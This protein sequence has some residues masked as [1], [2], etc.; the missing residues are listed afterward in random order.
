MIGKQ[1]R[2]L[3]K[4]AENATEDLNS[5]ITDCSD[6]S[7][8]VMPDTAALQLEYKVEYMNHLVYDIGDVWPAE[9]DF[10]Q[11]ANNANVVE[12]TQ[13]MDSELGNRSQTVNMDQL[14]RL[15]SSYRSWPEFRNTGTVQDII[16]GFKEDQP[17]KMPIVVEYDGYKQ[18][19]SGNTRLDI[20]FMMKVTPQ[21]LWIKI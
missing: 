21:V 3:V 9:E 4:K 10:L 7:N 14:L 12:L 17:M 15:V 13:A 1:A 18:I 5:L 2:R 8:W 6:F 19:M 20:A 16:E 11:A